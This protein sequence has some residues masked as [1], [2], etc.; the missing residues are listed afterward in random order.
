MKGTVNEMGSKCVETQPTHFLRDSL[1]VPIKQQEELLSPYK[2]LLLINRG[3]FWN[4][5]SLDVVIAATKQLQQQMVAGIFPSQPS[6][7]LTQALLGSRAGFCFSTSG[8]TKAEGRQLS[9]S[10]EK[11][12]IHNLLQQLS[13]SQPSQEEERNQSDLGRYKHPRSL[14]ESTNILQRGNL[15]QH[16]NAL[17]EAVKLAQPEWQGVSEAQA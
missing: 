7:A 8:Y 12:L 10:F 9:A 14:E 4:S 17:N 2:L 1:H 15:K 11:T 3:T 5:L 6:P 16:R 13:T